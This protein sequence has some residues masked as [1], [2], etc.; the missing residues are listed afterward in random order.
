MCGFIG[1]IDQDNLSDPDNVIKL[2]ADQIIHRGP[3]DEGYWSDKSHNIFLA[4]RRL[5]ILDLSVAGHQP[6]ISKSG[7]YILCFNGEIYNHLEIRKF[8]KHDL[9]FWR[10]H[11]D[12][13]TFLELVETVGITKALEQSVG[14][15]SLCCLDR[16]TKSLHLS[17][18]RFGEKPLYYGWVNKSFVFGSDLASFKKFTNFSNK[19]SSDAVNLFLNYSYI[20]TP[21]SIY[22]NIFKLE[23]GCLLSIDLNAPD[24]LKKELYWN[25]KEEVLRAKANPYRNLE[26]ASRD[27]E[28]KL[29]DSIKLQMIADVPLGSFLSGGIDSSLITS[30]MQ[31]SSTDKVQTFT[32]GFVDKQYDESGYARDVAKHLGTD[33]T[34]V[35]LTEKDALDTIPNLPN[36]Y[37]EPFAD[38]SQIPTYLVSKIAKSK[39]TVALSGDGGDEL[40]CGYNRYFWGDN[41]WNKIAIMPFALRRLLG[42]FALSMPKSAYANLER[43]LKGQLKSKG[44]SFLSDKI[45]KLANRLVYI[46][47]DLQLYH[48]LATQWNSIETLVLNDNESATSPFLNLA[49]DNNLSYVENMM[50]WDLETYMKDDILVKVDRAAMANSLETRAPFLDFRLAKA[51]F[52]LR[53]GLL[54]SGN[55]GK[56]VLRN[57]L[58][59][60]VPDSLIDRPKTGFG[61][62][63]G[64][65]LRNDLSDWAS[66]YL[67]KEMIES[68]NLLNYTYIENIW[69][70]HKRGYV[71]NTVKLWNILSL[72]SWVHS[73]KL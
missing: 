46:N 68:Q 52:R 67:S 38:S 15:F 61:I 11:S 49:I 55:T 4:F 24:K 66:S 54:H 57:I 32:I 31:K 70:D 6:M 9:S 63:V 19:Y 51:A 60:Y 16:K 20:P 34:E 41:I 3:D 22:E 8:L 50:L 58:N 12:S 37:S 10:G 28:E 5:S 33:H 72:I 48:S 1:F 42:Q 43:L 29:L 17:R 59:Q 21:L 25:S 64:S 7:R 30:L 27:I 23:S 69:L 44:I 65:W 53:G 14:M 26:E 2:M 35:I 56:L 47:S 73:N 62:P 36:I 45:E 40:F 71:D 39:V 13:E 18:D